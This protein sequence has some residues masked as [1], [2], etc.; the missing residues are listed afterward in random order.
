[1][2]GSR[3][4]K[5]AG[6]MGSE[7]LTYHERRALG[8]GTVKERLGKDSIGN[9]FDCGITLCPAVDPVCT[10]SGHLFSREAILE[11]LLEQKKANKRK[12]VAWEAQ[13]QEQTRKTQ[14]RAAIEQEAELLAFDRRNHM[15]A[16]DALASRLRDA[17]SEEAEVLL[18]DKHTVTG[19]VNI[20]QNGERIKEL[21]AF[22][23]PSKTPEARALLDK[24]D[25]QTICPAS[26]KKLRLKDLTPVHFAT[27][28]GGGEH[29]YMDPVS[30]D[31]LTN[32]SRLLVIKPSGDVVLEHTW[33]TC[34]LPEGSYKGTP[35]GPDDVIELQRGGTGFSAHDKSLQVTRHFTLGP[36]S[37]LADLRGQHHGPTSKFGLR[38]NN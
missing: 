16:S 23:M 25:G 20:R 5:N 6:T 14:D 30:R 17:I 24:P 11:N 38:F 10:P 33:K 7:S 22:W 35:V 28:P 2:G 19:A 37:G 27:V 3:H 31:V 26:G 36:G 21:R 12:L 34:I 32:A 13:Q 29:E 1:M 4:S 9:F 8:F 15:G 18:A